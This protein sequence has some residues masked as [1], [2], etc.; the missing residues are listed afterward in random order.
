MHAGAQQFRSGVRESSK[1]ASTLLVVFLLP[2]IMMNTN[3]IAASSGIMSTMMKRGAAVQK[4]MTHTQSVAFCVKSGI[5]KRHTH[6][7]TR[8][9]KTR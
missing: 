6:T 2:Q 7:P 3:Y 9:L 4:P 5:E 1:K 8:P